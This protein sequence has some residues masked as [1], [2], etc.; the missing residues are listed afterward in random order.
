MDAALYDPVHGFYRDG[1]AAGRRRDFITSPEVGPL[2][3]QLV[4]R[5]LD[6]WWSE[7]GEPD[8]FCVVEAAAGRGTLARSVVNAQPACLEALDYLLVETSPVLRAEHTDLIR[9]DSG[10][11]RVR[12]DAAMPA[13]A[14]VVLA[15]ELLDN[16]PTRI[17][18]VDDHGG[19]RELAVA[20][21]GGALIPV[22]IDAP[23]IPPA[24]AAV[25]GDLAP[26]TFVPWAVDAAS[27]V[28]DARETADVVTIIDYGETT[29]ALA[30]RPNAGWLRSYR[31]QA[32]VDD[33]FG[34]PGSADITVDVPIDQLPEPAMVVRQA[35]WLRGLGIDEL[36]DTARTVW[37][38]RA[39]IG[40]LAA[41]RARS[42][43]G[44][45]EALCDPAGLGAFHVLIWR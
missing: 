41:I 18:E 26:G 24:L 11:R 1:G 3:G 33:L 2:F 22:S 12:S 23:P 20:Q 30:R 38:E 29:A 44:E 8:P 16:L 10:A 43:I 5:A 13:Q 31:N 42:A 27:W 28:S 9:G 37:H 17:L 15:N 6:Q 14:H 39:S 40:D 34:A 19:C 45:A 32:R 35:D 36:V 4:A 21:E 25:V 7:L